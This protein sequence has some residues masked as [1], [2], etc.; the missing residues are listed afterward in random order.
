MKRT[1]G[2]EFLPKEHRADE[3]ETV[4][5]ASPS[6]AGLVPGPGCLAEP[7]HGS[8]LRDFPFFLKPA[9]L[10]PSRSETCCPSESRGNVMEV[11][12]AGLAGFTTMS[13]PIP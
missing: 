9:S 4:A 8:L 5:L 7:P 11:G 1:E 3:A 12:A 2:R 6:Q 10:T 13:E